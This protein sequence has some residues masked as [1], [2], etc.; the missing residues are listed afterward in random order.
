MNESER[1]LEFQRLAMVLDKIKLQ[2]ECGQES[3]KGARQEL[4]D[5]LAFF[6]EN[7]SANWWDQAQQAEAV[8]RGRSLAAVSWLRKSR[9][10]KMA[11]SPYFGRIDFQESRPVQ[12]NEPEPVYIGIAALTDTVT[13][14]N[15]IYDWR[16][17]IAGM[18]YDYEPGPAEYHCP[19]GIIQ[20]DI[21][22]KRQY[23]IVDGRILSMF[24]TDLKIDDEILQEILGKSADSKMR[25][26]VNSIQ[27][28][29][30]RVIR[31]EGHRLLLVQGPAGSGKTSIALHR[32]AYLLY[33]ER[34]TITAK[35][36]LILS[37]NRLFSDYISGVLP[38]LGEENVLQTTFRDYVLKCQSNFPGMVFEERDAQ[39]E[40]LLTSPDSQAY[41]TRASGIRFKS[42][43]EFAAIIRKF[44]A[45]LEEDLTSNSPDVEF[46]GR[47]ILPK[48]EWQT[49]FRINLAYL[50]L[51]E[52]L[53][54]LKHRVQIKLRPL[55]YELRRE[56]EAVIA[57]SGEEVNEKTIKALAR[58]EA[59][60]EL[61]GLSRQID[62]I[63]TLNPLAL[64]R[65]LFADEVL[66]QRLI[67]KV[68]VPPEWPD[69]RAHTIQSLDSGLIPYEDLLPLIFLQGNLA[70]FS[71]KRGI[72]H[73][74]IDEA[75]DYSIF[76]YEVLSRLFPESSWTVLGDPDQSVHPYIQ[77]VEFP[78]IARL[79]GITDTIS[80]R[81]KRSYRS[82]REI[83]AF[84]RG[85][86]GST[87]PVD[88]IN[89]PGPLPEV[90]QGGSGKSIAS[91]IAGKIR[92][93]QNAGWKSLAVLCKTARE[94]AELYQEL[95]GRIPLALITRETGEFTSGIVIIPVY[96][97]KG[98][99]FDGVF[100]AGAGAQNYST[101]ADQ[102]LLYIAC[103]RALHRLCLFYQGRCSPFLAGL[104]PDLYREFMI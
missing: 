78:V 51:A 73:V 40:Y 8:D 58:L 31:D 96:L 74:I 14:Q 17:P 44:L 3:F 16:S 80:I 41:R 30:N 85:I 61:A 50:P 25:T 104:P 66:F 76:H 29:Q 49:L 27:R 24:D 20:G 84:C 18:Y 91:V 7:R 90:Y 82:T 55:I 38:E 98:L 45:V 48:S 93:S 54:Q 21:S 86:L 64:Y 19:A 70:G 83:Q 97:A 87:E 36:I 9:L 43:P 72:R 52:R 101:D 59:Q 6:W 68:Q 67:E 65:Q 39:L 22:L 35:N 28:E 99:E 56:K 10:E 11:D 75:Q 2:L 95:N 79:L 103:T 71:V 12:R 1:E 37:P 77:A 92:E 34:N 23:K 42:S 100:I 47:T 53:A 89:R 26:I 88:Y 15:L 60:Q 4:Q 62:K 5:A 13:G 81:L 69:I 57:A 63:T 33:L 32:V 94:A 46:R 102:N